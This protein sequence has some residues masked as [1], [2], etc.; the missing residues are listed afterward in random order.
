MDTEKAKKIIEQ[1]FSL[2][3]TPVETVDYSLD[4]KKG[5]FF[6][7][8]SIEFDLI[9][10]EKEDVV[11]DMVYLL[12]RIFEKNSL[13]GE[14]NFKC[15]I[16][17]NNRQSKEDERIKMKALN[18]AEEARKLKTDVLMDP[19]SSYERM[20]VHSTLSDMVDIST[21]SIGEGRERRVKIKYLAI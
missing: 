11:K 16:D 13:P 2:I 14:E 9:S 10:N 7:V 17:I 1:I 8:K 21:E 19:M 5:H 12:R 3:G 20:L 6:S 18:Y 4:E 15:T